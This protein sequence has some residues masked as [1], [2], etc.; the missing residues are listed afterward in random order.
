MCLCS[1]SSINWYRP[2]A[3][4]VTV[5]LASHWPCIADSVVY[6][7]TGSMAWEMEMS[8]PPMLHLEY[9]YGIF[10]FIFRKF[11]TGEQLTKY[12]QK[13]CGLGT[14][15]DFLNYA[16]SIYFF[17]RHTFSDVGKPTSP[18]L[19]HTTWLGI[20]QNLCYTDFFKVPLKRTGAKNPKFAPY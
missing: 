14:K 1:P 2:L 9:Y 18:K 15:A 6:P 16:S 3:G 5:G 8:T 13:G 7:P 4:K 11:G 10:N 20:Q 19:S 17:S 12:S